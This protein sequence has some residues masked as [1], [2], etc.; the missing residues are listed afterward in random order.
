MTVYVVQQPVRKDLKSGQLVPS[1]DLTPALEYG[2]L[3]SLLAPGQV[4]LLPAQMLGA[5][6][7]GLKDFTD[8]DYLLP[9]GDP[10]A[11]AAASI[12]AAEFNRGRVKVLR[13]DG[14]ARAYM[15]IPLYIDRRFQDA[16]N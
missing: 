1:M 14:R 8:D 15:V 3:V 2:E 13:W 16:I 6:R 10:V 4:A 12:V 9:V 7:H 11:I 5:L